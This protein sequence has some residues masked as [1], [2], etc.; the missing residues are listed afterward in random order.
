MVQQKRAVQGAEHLENDATDEQH[1]ASKDPRT[2]TSGKRC[3]RD[4][5]SVRAACVGRLTAVQMPLRQSVS[6]DLSRA[7]WYLQNLPRLVKEAVEAGEE[8]VEAFKRE[9]AKR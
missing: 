5:K 8:V 1:R 2:T 7:A 3:S 6:E 4:H 9:G